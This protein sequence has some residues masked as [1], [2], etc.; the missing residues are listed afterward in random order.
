MS[1]LTLIVS[2]L[3]CFFLLCRFVVGEF[4][5]RLTACTNAVLFFIFLSN[6]KASSASFPA[7]SFV[8]PQVT[9]AE[10]QNLKGLESLKAMMDAGNAPFEGAMEQAAS[11][12]DSGD[13][14]GGW[15]D[16]ER[17]FDPASGD[18]LDAGA[19][20]EMVQMRTGVDG[21]NDEE[22]GAEDAAEGQTEEK[23]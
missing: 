4:Q 15:S 6:T 11:T 21:N 5:A 1:G 12:G 23:K 16:E 7:M 17:E 14:D 10:Q 2:L 20:R 3:L 18:V 19:L 8:P 9:A 13:D 22:K